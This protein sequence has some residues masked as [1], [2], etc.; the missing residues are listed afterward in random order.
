MTIHQLLWENLSCKQFI[1]WTLTNSEIMKGC[2][3]IIEIVCKELH[4]IENN[5]DISINN[6]DLLKRVIQLSTVCKKICP[7][8]KEMYKMVNF[9]CCYK[10]YD[11]NPVCMPVTDVFLSGKKIK[12]RFKLTNQ[13]ICLLV[14][15]DL[16]YYQDA[17]YVINFPDENIVYKETDIVKLIRYMSND[18]GR[19][20]NKTKL[21]GTERYIRECVYNSK[22]EQKILHNIKYRE[23]VE[24]YNIKKNERKAHIKSI[25]TYVSTKHNMCEQYMK[26]LQTI[27]DSNVCFEY[28]TQL[29]D[30][31][32]IK[33]GVDNMISI[34]CEI[35]DR[36]NTFDKL[37]HT[38]H[39]LLDDLSEYKKYVTTYNYDLGY[40]DLIIKCK[41]HIILK[42]KKEYTEKLFSSKWEDYENYYKFVQSTYTIQ[43][44]YNTWKE[45]DDY[46]T[47][48]IK[49]HWIDYK[50]NGYEN[51]LIVLLN[52]CKE[53]STLLFVDLDLENMFDRDIICDS[54]LL[55]DI[56]SLIDEHVVSYKYD[57]TDILSCAYN[58]ATNNYI[59]IYTNFVFENN[60]KEIKNLYNGNK[61]ID[62]FF[63]WYL[64][65]FN[66]I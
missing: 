19:I 44:Y 41:K 21:E 65:R 61:F 38:Y 62:N 33:K 45:H 2:H 34:V 49:D 25:F 20:T 29:L 50:I 43:Y 47:S 46:D 5:F 64:T 7:T 53:Y 57:N 58:T 15:K 52:K 6:S 10:C 54:L 56:T 22:D 60:D 36:Y 4:L 16:P 30:W 39:H 32:D 12:K 31:N 37:F 1:L 13:E 51:E 9:K 18:V 8:C 59:H 17:E 42:K 40:N 55:Y 26:R 35:S 28:T 3:G 11:Y 63:P 27:L 23:T 14:P 66:N 48:I 24:S